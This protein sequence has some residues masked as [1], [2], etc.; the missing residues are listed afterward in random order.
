LGDLQQLGEVLREHKTLERIRLDLPPSYRTAFVLVVGG[1][2]TATMLIAILFARAATRRIGRL[3]EGTRRV[4]EG[5]L[6]TRVALGGSD[7][8]S[9]L[10]R[11][12]DDMVVEIARSRTEIEYLQKIGA[13]QEVARRMAHEIKNPL[14]PIQLAVQQLQSKYQGDDPRFRKMLDD[15]GEIV[16]EEIAGLRRLVEAFSGFA[17][18]PPVDKKRL[19]LAQVA[20]DVARDATAYEG[21]ALELVAPAAPVEVPAD[22]LL[23]RRALVNL[24]ENAA[25]AGAKRV[26][27]A[28]EPDEEGGACITLDDDGSGVPDNLRP[29]LFDPYVTTKALG[30]GLG[31][32]IVKKTILEHGG[33]IELAAGRSTWGGAQFLVTL[34]SV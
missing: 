6:N 18:M 17:K 32:A 33:T 13:W 26:R 4:A 30:T 23:L 25:Q 31:L 22:R 24:V 28:W 12:F 5:D 7:E 19:D 1:F 8:L 34:P 2:A 27:L 16:T 21:L 9:D 20:E 11:A 3:V 15:A 29:T 14:T 10:A